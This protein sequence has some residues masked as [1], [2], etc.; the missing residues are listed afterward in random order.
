LKT[1]FWLFRNYEEARSAVEALLDL[2][3]DPNELNA[4]IVEDEAKEAMDVNWATAAVQVSDQEEAPHG[5]QKEPLRGLDRLLAREQGV[6]LDDVGQV[7]AG[8]ELATLAV[9][10]AASPESKGQG[11]R[12]AL[13]D[14][15][16]DEEM[17][18]KSV[19]VVGAGG[20]LVAVRLPDERASQVHWELANLPGQPRASATVG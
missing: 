8:G 16:V 10:A 13:L 4:I 1:L 19:D 14:L 11:L 3:I 12:A 2:D 6:S 17:A 18:G 9:N 20:V 15:G 5:Q 7:L